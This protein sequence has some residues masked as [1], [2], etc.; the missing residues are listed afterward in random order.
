MYCQ[1]MER[2]KMKKPSDAIAPTEE[3]D[4]AIVGRRSFL[5][6]AGLATGA[7]TA[8]GATSR[9][10]SGNVTQPAENAQHSHAQARAF[11]CVNEPHRLRK[12]F[13]DLTDVEVRLLCQAVGYM[14]NGSKDKPLSIADSFQWDQW[15]MMHARHCTEAVPGTQDQVH[16]SWF[17]LP[18]HRAYLWF[19]ERHLA[20]ILTAVFNEDGSKFALPYW[21]WTSH[22][23]I[24]NTRERVGRGL[25]SPLFGY[26]LTMEDMVNADSLG[27]DNQALWNGYRKPNIQ[28]PTMDPA[29][30]QSKDSKDHISETIEYMKPDSIR[31]MLLLE[32]EDFAGKAVAPRST[33]PTPDCM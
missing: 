25:N 12:S 20:H 16:W 33:I 4:A 22:R 30:E 31:L 18:W 28:H 19:L 23:E 21:D 8:V 3:S 14:R 13:Y 15:V 10:A 9:V 1:T 29:N 24:P 2:V 27:F 6:R 17:F 7:L 26:D 5:I 11:Q 32:F